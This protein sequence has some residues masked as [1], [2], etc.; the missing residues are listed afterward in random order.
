M[1]SK[2]M[3]GSTFIYAVLLSSCSFQRRITCERIT[4][5]HVVST[6]DWN[7][8][9]HYISLPLSIGEV[10]ATGPRIDKSGEFIVLKGATLYYL[11]YSKKYNTKDFSN[12]LL[13]L[14]IRNE[15]LLVQQ[16]D[17]ILLAPYIISN[18]DAEKWS[19]KRPAKVIREHSDNEFLPRIAADSPN[20]EARC[21][22]YGLLKNGYIVS[23]QHDSGFITYK[24]P[25]S[26]KR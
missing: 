25:F 1:T 20:Y 3:R 2:P 19:R 15:A 17:Y 8:G 5:A 14:L 7:L 24:R 26:D 18:A 6:A 13:S 22:L 21:I 23:V 12:Y 4:S 10:Q 11:M 9:S 16:Q